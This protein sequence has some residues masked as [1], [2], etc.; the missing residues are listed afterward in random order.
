[1][2]I[3]LDSAM[4]PERMKEE[5]SIPERPSVLRGFVHK[6]IRRFRFLRAFT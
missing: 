1:V 3:P 5:T 4:T 6:R 2:E